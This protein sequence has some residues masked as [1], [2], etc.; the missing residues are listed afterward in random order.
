[1]RLADGLELTASSA[2]LP[3][4]IQSAL[5]S[6]RP[7]KIHISKRPVD[8]ENISEIRVQEEILQGATEQLWLITNQ[9]ARLPALV[10]NE[11]AMNEAYHE[12]N[13]FTAAS[14]SMIW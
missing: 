3:A 6:I 13:E 14:I 7:Q 4:A 8:A 2:E 11:S 9:G 10:A 12:A 1:M 5:V